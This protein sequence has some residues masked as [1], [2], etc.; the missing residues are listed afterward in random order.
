VGAGTVSAVLKRMASTVFRP[1]LDILPAAQR[2]RWAELDRTPDE[3]AYGDAILSLPARP[4]RHG[5]L[6]ER[7]SRSS[8]A[9]LQPCSTST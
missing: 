6:P 1:R 2:A 7:Y 4:R 9:E 8:A 5:L 3:R